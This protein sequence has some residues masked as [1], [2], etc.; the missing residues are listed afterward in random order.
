M[1]RDAGAG[2]NPVSGTVGALGCDTVADQSRAHTSQCSARTEVR[3]AAPPSHLYEA[4]PRRHGDPLALPKSVQ[5]L[6]TDSLPLR[7]TVG[8]GCCHQHCACPLCL[9]HVPQLLT[10][11]QREP[12]KVGPP[13]QPVSCQTR[14]TVATRVEPP[15]AEGGHTERLRCTR[16]AV[17]P[18]ESGERC[19][20]PRAQRHPA[21]LGSTRRRLAP[22][23][24]VTSRSPLLKAAAS[25]Y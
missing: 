4:S 3:H 23:H 18:P 8:T 1:A 25:A 6:P 17:S 9:R 19:P 15:T 2:S 5:T 10:E 22:A 14:K 24:A 16:D 13:S 7:V 12:A 20:D 21:Q 11:Q